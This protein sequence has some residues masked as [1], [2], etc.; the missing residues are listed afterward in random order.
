MIHAWEIWNALYQNQEISVVLVNLSPLEAVPI[1]VR[2]G[3]IVIDVP[4]PIL[5]ESE[6]LTERLGDLSDPLIRQV[7]LQFIKNQGL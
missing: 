3:A 7:A 2:N 4:H 6:Q 5:L 1:L